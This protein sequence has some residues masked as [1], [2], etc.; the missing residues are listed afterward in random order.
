MAKELTKSVPLQDVAY[1]VS[2]NFGLVFNSQMLWIESLDALLGGP[3]GVP[4][5][6]P[7]ELRQLHE[8]ED[9]FWA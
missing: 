8:E 7:V 5:R 9:T 2:R 4:V 1:V 6:P 3:V